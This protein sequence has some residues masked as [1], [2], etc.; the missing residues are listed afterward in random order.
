LANLDLL[1]ADIEEESKKNTEGGLGSL[2]ASMESGWCV[3]RDAQGRIGHV[4]I[5]PRPE[6]LLDI[7]DTS[8]KVKI[9]NGGT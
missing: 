5:D 8:P 2:F 7:F 9:S 1:G 6:Y 3:M 4:Y